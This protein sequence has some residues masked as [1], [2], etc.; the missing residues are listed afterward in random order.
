MAID[1]K[2]APP[3]HTLDKCNP[4]LS[5]NIKFVCDDDD[6]F[7]DSINSNAELSR[8]LYKSYKVNESNNLMA[9]AKNFF[10][11]FTTKDNIFSVKSDKNYVVSTF[12]NQH[13]RIYNYGAYSD[14]SEL[15]TKRFRFF[16]PMFI[17]EESTKPDMFLIY[18]VDRNKFNR[19]NDWKKELLF[20]HDFRKSNMG[21][22]LDRHIDYL[23]NY[24]HDMGVYVNMGDNISYTG[25]S[26]ESGLMTARYEDDFN[27]LL[28]NERTITEFNDYIVDGFKRNSVID[29][30][31]L[32]LEFAFDMDLS[33]EDVN[34]KFVDVIGIYVTLDEFNNIKEYNTSNY[35]FKLLEDS[36]NI[37]EVLSKTISD[38]DLKDNLVNVGDY[39]GVQYNSPNF[40]GDFPPIVMIKPTFIPNVG[41]V[42]ELSFGGRTEIKYII[43]DSDIVSSDIMATAK[44]ISDSFKE[45]A[46]INPS[47]IFVDSFIQDGEYLVI[48]S[49]LNDTTYN[50]IQVT[51]LPKQ[52][53]IVEPLF[54]SGED[55][56]NNFYSPSINSVITNSPIG[57]S[58][59]DADSIRLGNSVSKITY[60]G[61]WLSFYFF[62]TEE[63]LKTKDSD[64]QIFETIRTERSKMYE[65]TVL[66]HRKFDF[67]REVS[68]HEDVFDFELQTYRNWLLSEINS[69]S[70]L[71][72]YTDREQPSIDVLSDYKA[73]LVDIV[74]RYFESISINRSMLFK[75]VSTDDFEATSVSNEYDRLKEN[76]NKGLLTSNMTVQHINKFMYA[77]GLDVYNRPY[78]LNLNLPFRYGN[79]AP[80]LDNTKRDLRD[81]THSWLVIGEGLPP[82]F[83]S[84]DI[85]GDPVIK[86]VEVETEQVVNV[87]DRIYD[88]ISSQNDIDLWNNSE[89]TLTPSNDG[90]SV[91]YNQDTSLGFIE[92]VVDILPQA[93][94]SETNFQ[95]KFSIDS[96]ANL[97]VNVRISLVRSLDRNVVYNIWDINRNVVGGETDT[98]DDIVRF[99]LP[100]DANDCVLVFSV[101]VGH[102]CTI[103]IFDLNFFKGTIT[104]DTLDEN[105]KFD[106]DNIQ[107]TFKNLPDILSGYTT[108]PI[109]INDIKSSN[110][111]VYNYI[112]SNS[113]IREEDGNGTC[114]FRGVKCVVNKK[115][116]G[117][118]FSAVLI[119][120]TAP[121]GEDRAIQL[122]ENNTFNSLTLVVNMYIPEPV[123][124]SLEQ[125]DLYWLDRSLLYFSD[126]NYATEESLASFGLEDLSVRINDVGSPKTYLGNVVTN[127][128]FYQNGGQNFIHVNKGIL[129]RFN[130]NFTSLLTLGSSFS[131]FYSNVEDNATVN[132]GMLITF[133]EV[134]EIQDD[135]FWCSEITVNIKETIDGVTNEIEYDMLDTYLNNNETFFEDNRM[136]IV[137]A[138]LLEN[139]KYN[140]LL[141][142]TSAI[143]RFSLLSTASIF[144]W[145]N[146]NNVKV[147]TEDG[148]T[149]F[150]TMSA[151]KPI[152]KDGVIR[153]KEV[154]NNIVDLDLKY[155]NTFVRQNGA[156]N[157]VTKLLRKRTGNYNIE[158]C[159][160]GY[161]NKASN[162]ELV[163]TLRTNLDRS[164]DAVW[165][166]RNDYANTDLKKH[167]RYY[168]NRKDFVELP[169]YT[170]PIEYKHE[171]SR[172][173][174][175][176]K[177]LEF[178]HIYDGNSIDIYDKI[179]PY[180]VRVM[181]N[182]GFKMS[183]Y[184]TDEKIS[185]L[186]LSN[187]NINRET[188][189]QFDF[190][191]IIMR[192]FYK[193]VIND[194]YTVVKVE[195]INKNERLDFFEE[196]DDIIQLNDVVPNGT[197]LRINVDRI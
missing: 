51:V 20:S 130:V 39:L 33:D 114:F 119:T 35:D 133:K 1:K 46:R 118:K 137:E 107:G 110:T 24:P 178:T 138:I 172:I 2:I 98:I 174:S 47:N 70:F 152:V 140:R 10:D 59:T 181:N 69:D 162:N 166:Y 132:Y 182:T 149:H 34:D 112:R 169:W 29:S 100:Q 115:Y 173:L 127:D 43:K 66:E 48:R 61:K 76:D 85:N 71:G 147:N 113:L 196:D 86:R 87:I 62:D 30:R 84:I 153:Y 64:P 194:I 151:F 144:E 128:W 142:N 11:L 4:R 125:P 22:Q 56:D 54:T 19:N 28:A 3:I 27:S 77:N 122:Y 26:I 105:I 23:K 15:L 92:R 176:K 191:D 129:S 190:E 88:N 38:V 78:M 123:L 102:S 108:I 40:I 21:K 32:N 72:K 184:T 97:N 111:D 57:I 53:Q 171:L 90:K 186:R 41:D 52:Y 154:G 156:Y 180:L 188:F 145:L 65:C 75:D 63:P 167:F 82:Y 139:A 197:E 159:D 58:L 143:D 163:P 177:E 189:D 155:T 5:G 79:F 50:N 135:Y 12:E 25:T 73:E 160:Y 14:E 7:I 8:S 94:S 109:S 150:D 187:P 101:P 83:K 175:S 68:Y 158:Y 45:Y 9:N 74:E 164:I 106:C 49:L 44:N 96:S 183:D 165:F 179:K 91:V 136:D 117:W 36:G 16:A 141:R 148:S 168:L 6:I 157:P 161:G 13:D 192:R 146:A 193:S 124:T 95:Y 195:D 134:Q 185:M 80:S 67:D 17:N 99:K 126:G 93:S 55:Y 116:V 89:S 42:I 131:A 121:I 81:S 37:R 103:N 31:H 120:R 104:Q 60:G 18:R 170:N